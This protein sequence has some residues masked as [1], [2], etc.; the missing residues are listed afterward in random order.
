MS[1][2][3][4]AKL[5][6]SHCARHQ[7]EGA[8]EDI[9]AYVGESDKKAAQWR[10]EELRDLCCSL[11]VAGVTKCRRIR[12]AGHTYVNNMHRRYG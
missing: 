11:H 12:W 8:E 6:L 3:I 5:G 9:W 4:S 7:S 2:G 1:V 10:N